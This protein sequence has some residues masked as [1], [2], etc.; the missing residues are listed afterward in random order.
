MSAVLHCE[1]LSR[2]FGRRQALEGL[3]FTLARGEVLGLLGRNGAGKSTA[4][5][6]LSGSLAPSAGRVL[7][8]GIDL[9]RRPLAAKRH[10]GYLP[11][12]APLHPEMRVDEFLAYAA[13]LRRLP[14]AALS[15]ALERVKAQCG[16]AGAGRRL[17]GRLSKGYRQRVGLAQALLHEP[18]LLILDEPTDGLDP[19]QVRA[20]RGVI[21][22]LARRSAIL[23]SSHALTEVQAL[24]SQVVI[25]DGGRARYRAALGAGAAPGAELYVRLRPPPVPASLRALR[26][27]AAAAAD[28]PGAARI[29]LHADA[30]PDALARALIDHG[31]GLLELR[32]RRSELEQVFFDSLAAEPAA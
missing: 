15:P 21:G 25:L 30:T 2:R 17:L 10:L 12:R 20:L 1:R 24:C 4:L 29:R 32:P 27:V 31:Y 18:A 11:E 22:A 16:L 19:V 6:I 5:R 26:P 23:L 7:V 8:A 3:E 14:R 28:G 9:H 13:R